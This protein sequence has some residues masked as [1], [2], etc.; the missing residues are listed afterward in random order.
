ML[1]NARL[2][3]L[4][5]P[6]INLEAMSGMRSMLVFVATAVLFDGRFTIVISL[7]RLILTMSASSFA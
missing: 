2:K 1:V 4:F 3:G 5:L 6:F 7:E